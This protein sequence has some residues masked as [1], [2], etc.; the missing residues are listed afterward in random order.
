MEA[1]LLARAQ[2]QS[3]QELQTAVSTLAHV[4]FQQCAVYVLHIGIVAGAQVFFHRH[5]GCGCHAISSLLPPRAGPH[6]SFNPAGQ[7]CCGLLKSGSPI[8]R[9]AWFG[10]V[11]AAV[12]M[13]PALMTSGLALP[14]KSD[15]GA[16]LR[17]ETPPPAARHAPFRWCLGTAQPCNRRDSCHFP[18]YAPPGPLRNGIELRSSDGCQADS[19]ISFLFLSKYSVISIAEEGPTASG[20]LPNRPD[21]GFPIE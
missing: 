18:F 6:T 9:P 4:S 3:N 5:D 8:S 2:F 13:D 10:I 12:R 14:L 21:V 17:G 16:R 20:T 19:Q 11:A 15:R 7:W 1:P